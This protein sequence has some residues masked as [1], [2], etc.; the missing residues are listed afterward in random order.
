MKQKSVT[1][2]VERIVTSSWDEV[3]HLL[4]EKNTR[5]MAWP[6]RMDR[7]AIYI[8]VKHNAEIRGG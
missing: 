6:Y 3:K 5:L 2:S 1:Q 7:T 4:T 8:I